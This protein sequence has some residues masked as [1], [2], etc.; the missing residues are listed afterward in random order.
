[1]AGFR[2]GHHGPLVSAL[3]LGLLLVA[4]IKQSGGA[5]T[6][7][8]I[9]DDA[10][11]ASGL[12]YT[13]TEIAAAFPADFIDNLTTTKTYRSKVPLQIGDTVADGGGSGTATT[14]LVDTAAGIY[15][16]TGK[17]LQTRATQ[18]TS[19]NIKTGTKVGT[20]NRAGARDGSKIITGAGTTYR[21]NFLL[22]GSTIESEGAA[23]AFTPAVS[24]LGSEIIDCKI[25]NRGTSVTSQI[26]IG[27]TTL[28]LANVYNVDFDGDIISATNALL[29][30]FNASNAERITI[31]ISGAGAFLRSTQTNLAVKD[32]LL[33]GTPQSVDVICA[34]GIPSWDF[35]K[36]VWS[37]ATR[38]SFTGPVAAGNVRESWLYTPKVVDQNGTGVSGISVKVTDAVG[39]VQVNTTTDSGGEITFGSGITT[40]SLIVRDHY[41]TAGPVYT[42]RDRFPY[43]VE[44]NTVN[45]NLNFPAP[46]YYMS[47]PG[48]MSGNFGDMGDAIPLLYASGGPTLWTELSL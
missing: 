12:G 42:T 20:G 43:L 5:G 6:L 30:S 18:L 41:A 7:I 4:G 47:P 40:Q 19:W 17:V 45:Q 33:Y 23:M 31:A 14:T 26:A 22:Y 44:V 24:G 28:A 21:G 1:M 29:T 35:V 36:P 13:R 25:R 11:S 9:Y 2:Q 15:F 38:F 27:T 16:D 46:R 34:T 10:S 39:T 48:S 37:G 32:I 3:L 8:T